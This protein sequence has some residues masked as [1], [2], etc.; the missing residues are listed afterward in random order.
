MLKLLPAILLSLLLQDGTI[1]PVNVPVKTTSFD[2]GYGTVHSEDLGISPKTIQ[3][4]SPGWQ[5]GTE[6][7]YT[8]AFDVVNYFP[9]YPGYYTAEIDFG[10]QELCEASGWGMSRMSHITIVCPGSNYIVLAK[11][12]PLGG[13]VQGAQNLVLHFTVPGWQLLFSNVN[14]TFQP[15]AP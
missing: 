9:G 11:A 3:A 14:L 15:E 10:T 7:T 13:P 6:G 5:Y 8:L 2:I 1:Q 4:P 12:L